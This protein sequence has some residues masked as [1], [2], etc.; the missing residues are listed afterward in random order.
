MR[1]SSTYLFL[2]TFTLSLS[3]SLSQY[4]SVSDEDGFSIPSPISTP[5]P[6]SSLSSS[7]SSLA[8]SDDFPTSCPYELLSCQSGGSFQGNCTEWIKKCA[9]DILEEQRLNPV[10]TCPHTYT[11]ADC[12]I[13][14]NPKISKPNVS[15]C[16][17]HEEF[18]GVVVNLNNEKKHFECYM[19]YDTAKSYSVRSHRVILDVERPDFRHKRTAN[20]KFTITSRHRN[21]SIT[22]G[23]E[24]Y[25]ECWESQKDL[26]CDLQDCTTETIGG[27]AF[28][29]CPKGVCHSCSEVQPSLCSPLLNPIFIK[30]PVKFSFSHMDAFQ[31]LS[32]MVYQ[33]KFG[34]FKMQC[35]TGACSKY[36]INTNYSPAS[37][38]TWKTILIG[39]VGGGFLLLIAVAALWA[40]RSGSKSYD[41]L[42]SSEALYKIEEEME[43]EL[44]LFGLSFH[45]VRYRVTIPTNSGESR[46]KHV[47]NGICGYVRPRELVALMG[48]SGAG[49]S[50]LM[51][52]LAGRDKT[53]TVTGH[54]SLI[55][56]TH[57]AQKRDRV[58]AYVPQDDH[59]LHT[60]TVRES[61]TFSA[62]MRLPPSYTNEMIAAKVTRTLRDLKILHIADSRIGHADA[63][64]G[65]S[66]GERKRVAIGIELVADPRVLLLDEPTSGLDSYSAHIVM[67]VLKETARKGCACVLTIHQP[68]SK[69]YR[70]F[71]QVL[72]LSRIGSQAFYGPP[73]A[74]VEHFIDSGYPQ[75][76]KFTNPAEYV[77]DVV[78]DH[79]QHEKLLD[80]PVNFFASAAYKALTLD[81]TTALVH[82]AIELPMGDVD[83]EQ[84]GFYREEDELDGAAGEILVGSPHDVDLLGGGSAASLR[85][86]EVVIG[87]VR[88]KSVDVPPD[89]HSHNGDGGVVAPVKKEY[90]KMMNMAGKSERE[91]DDEATPFLLSSAP[92][93]SPSSLSSSSLSL[94]PPANNGAGVNGST[95]PSLSAA[96]PP[97]MHWL[98]LYNRPRRSMCSRVGILLLRSL[99]HLAREPSLLAAQWLLT[100]LLA[101]FIGGIFYDLDVKKSGI[102]NRL[103]F[104]FFSIMYFSLISTTSLSAFIA[105]TRLFLRE[106]AARFYTT[107]P[108]FISKFICDVIPLRVLPPMLY[109]SVVYW[110]MGLSNSPD[111]FSRFIVI[112]VLVNVVAASACFFFSAIVRDVGTATLFASLFFI[113]CTLFG[114]L[115][116]ANDPDSSSPLVHLTSL[117]YFYYGYEAL[118]VNE[119]SALQVWFNPNEQLDMPIPGEAVLRFFH[120]RTTWMYKDMAVLAGFIGL[121]TTSA[122]VAL[123]FRKY[124]K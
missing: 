62:R 110:M 115:F 32:R 97:H 30:W 107:L 61:L 73:M 84:E 23:H 24:H 111:K 10:C 55:C 15:H 8:L 41:G 54:V 117:S 52:I 83:K 108:Y 92:R 47:L 50:S 67:S 64:G 31:G 5:L 44:P 70:M 75:P 87:Q 121:F 46:V 114:G 79:D 59:I 90:K 28:Y 27:E 39:A 89:Y 13:L 57:G 85:E 19:D 76:E 118:N 21:G 49:K 123:Y 71:D 11:G 102:Q 119:F 26:D 42:M 36:T 88:R 51:D 94:P 12:A 58:V 82:G 38:A 48:S 16:G 124:K 53:G 122:F 40:R 106:R 43:K 20:V 37:P 74:A 95:P 22:K 86:G 104:F 33:T 17:P 4:T 103:G 56:T 34:I 65:I 100:L 25:H 98:P 35:R 1:A 2:I 68:P 7:F 81:A 113:F 66:G 29:T 116:L 80:L 112:L 99:K 69:I 60:Q 91:R 18:D 120:L 45:D 3:L 63:G 14:V 93:R 72:L 77:L 96:T 101:L 6:P 78:S 9:N 109:G 105:E